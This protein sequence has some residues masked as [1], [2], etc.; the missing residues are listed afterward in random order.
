MEGDLFN[1]KEKLGENE[2]LLDEKYFGAIEE[3]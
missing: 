3:L 2:Y 1:S